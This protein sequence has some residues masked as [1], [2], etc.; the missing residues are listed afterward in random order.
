MPPELGNL[1]NLM[2]LDL[3]S[4]KLTGSIPPE[5]GS[6]IQLKNLLLHTNEL[7]GA[8][9]PE[10][11]QLT[12]LEWLGIHQNNQLTGCVP[13]PLARWVK[14]W[15]VCPGLAIFRPDGFWRHREGIWRSERPVREN[16]LPG[17][18]L[19]PVRTLS[20]V[21]AILTFSLAGPDSAAF[22]IDAA[23]ELTVGSGTVLN[24]E[25]KRSYTVMVHLSDGLDYQG[26]VDP[27]IDDT[28][29]VA[30]RVSNVE[31]PGRVTLSSTR[32]VVG[33]PLT[34]TLSDP[35]GLVR[36]NPPRWQW[37]HRGSADTGVE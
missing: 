32:P 21:G 10:L 2:W 8:I 6:L 35:D 28:L 31:E 29:I 14:S 23:G 30:I 3:S 11:A 17:Q 37:Q 36:Y 33:E 13:A 22:A 7:T 4:N 9:P 18:A 15:P 12:R 5:L 20:S 26:L 19:G 25:A 1:T 34:V 27:R 16:T 24:Y